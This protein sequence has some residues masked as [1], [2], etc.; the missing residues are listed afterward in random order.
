MSFLTDQLDS[1]IDRRNLLQ[2][3]AFAGASLLGAGLLAGCGGSSNNDKKSSGTSDSRNDANI[4]NFALNLEYLEAEFYLRAV[5]GQGLVAADIGG[6]GAGTVV[7]PSG[8]AN[9]SNNVLQYALEIASDEQNHV[10]A[11]RSTIS[12]LGY[13]P[14]VRPDI[15]LTDTF[16]ALAKLAGLGNSFDPY[17]SDTNF[18]LAS[19][20]F[21]D[22]GVTAYSGAATAIKSAAVL[23]AAAGILAVEAYHSGAI[24][25]LLVGLGATSQADAISGVRDSVDGG[26]DDDQ[27]ISGPD[28]SFGLSDTLTQSNFNL[29]PADSN[30]IA[31]SRTTDQV[32]RVVYADA[33]GSAGA[34]PGGFFPRGI[35]FL[36]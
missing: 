20:I 26:T 13:T 2:R 8:T 9:L 12:Q 18:L 17:A 33:S 21:E 3:G 28:P 35:N 24:R 27:G 6:T 34:T 30:S 15:N 1:K 7:A 25:T 5:T 11:I 19:F 14:S 23:K 36:K 16:N 10:R 22:V 32:L 31:F 4:L 29:V